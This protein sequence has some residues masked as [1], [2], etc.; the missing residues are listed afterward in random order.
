MPQATMKLLGIPFMPAGRWLTLWS[1]WLLTATLP[2]LLSISAAG[3]QTNL[4]FTGFTQ[5][6]N[7][8]VSLI[9]LT[10]YPGVG[11]YRV[12]DSIGIQTSNNTPIRVMGMDGSLVYSG[13]VTTLHLPVGHYFVETPGDRT[14]FV[15]LPADSGSLDRLAVNGT[16]VWGYLDAINNSVGATWERCDAGMWSDVQTQANTYD[17]SIAD[18]RMA[19]TKATGRRIVYVGANYPP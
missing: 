18:A 8:A 3:T 15:V 14:Q 6:F 1:V 7:P 11:L 5:S 13:A 16:G 10:P 19:V 4:S 2:F 12:G 17:W 9:T